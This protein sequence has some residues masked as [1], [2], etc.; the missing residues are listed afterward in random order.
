MNESV[1]KY[2]NKLGNK[3]KD[4]FG[5]LGKLLTKQDQMQDTSKHELERPLLM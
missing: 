3:N 2:I 4:I 5:I 1:K